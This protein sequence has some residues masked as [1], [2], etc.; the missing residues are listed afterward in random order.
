[1]RLYTETE[2]ATGSVVVVQ[3][4]PAVSSRFWRGAAWA[5]V[6]EVVLLGLGVLVALGIA[7]LF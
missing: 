7:W 4:K 6:L 5:L 3:P 1:M 2:E